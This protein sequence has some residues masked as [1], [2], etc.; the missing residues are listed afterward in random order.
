MR[1]EVLTIVD[2]WHATRVALGLF[3]YRVVRLL[4]GVT[5]KQIINVYTINWNIILSLRQHSI[6]LESGPWVQASSGDDAP[7]MLMAGSLL[8]AIFF[9]N[10][11][12][13]L[14]RPCVQARSNLR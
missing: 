4:L 5:V 8:E 11:P 7:G 1:D 3:W 12:K 10:G 14:Q 13:T 9:A 2:G 6:H